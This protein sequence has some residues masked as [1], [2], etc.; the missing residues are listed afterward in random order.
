MRLMRLQVACRKCNVDVNSIALDASASLNASS[1]LTL[2]VT[3]DA[4]D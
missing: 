3:Q 1:S 4:S 2:F